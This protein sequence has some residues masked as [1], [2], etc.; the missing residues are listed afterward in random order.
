[1]GLLWS[2]DEAQSRTTSKDGNV[3]EAAEKGCSALT[4]FPR[5]WGC[6]E[7]SAG[8]MASLLELLGMRLQVMRWGSKS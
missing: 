4:C 2:E 6:G 8:T 1:M 3:S 5:P 7:L